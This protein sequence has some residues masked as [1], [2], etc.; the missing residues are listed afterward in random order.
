MFPQQVEAL[1]K[2][3]A[4]AAAAAAPASALLRRPRRP[5]PHPARRRSPARSGEWPAEPDPDLERQTPR[6]DGGNPGRLIRKPPHHVLR[7]QA[8]P[9]RRTALLAGVSAGEREKWKAQVEA[10]LK[11][12]PFDKKMFSSTYEGITLQPI[13]GRRTSPGW[14]TGIRCRVPRPSSG[15]PA[16]GGYGRAWEVSQEIATPRCGRRSTTPHASGLERGLTAL[17]VVVDRAT[18]NGADPGLGPEAEI[19]AGGLSVASLEDADAHFEGIDLDDGAH[20]R[21]LRGVGH[22]CGGA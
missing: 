3:S 6:R 8:Q 15:E 20:V 14:R 1:Y 17:N 12:A 11:G 13:Y 16:S 10:E 2:T 21:P 22:A 5:L 7:P 19:G 4:P 9:S 18:R